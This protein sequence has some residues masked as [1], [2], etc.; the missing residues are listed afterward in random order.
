M[1]SQSGDGDLLQ[2]SRSESSGEFVLIA[3]QLLPRPRH[4][5]FE[6]FCDAFQLEALTPPWLNFSVLTPAPIPMS[7]GTLI[8]Y[9]LG[10]HGL[11]LKWQSRIEVWEPP[12]RFVDVQVRG[13]YRRWHH[14][15]RFEELDDGTLCR[16][17]VHYSVPGGRLVEKCLVRP[18]LV[19][20]FRFRQ[21]RLREL[22]ASTL[23][24]HA[25]GDPVS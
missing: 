9:R 24:P 10:V 23:S 11:P 6:F 19:R 15:H 16:D 5:V 4:E 8:D 21:A 14:E 25:V 17:V 3:E 18:D 2:F 20:I 1:T 22:F 7:A 12:L 13:P